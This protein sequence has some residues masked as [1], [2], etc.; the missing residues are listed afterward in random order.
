MNNT[1][2]SLYGICKIIIAFAVVIST[3]GLMLNFTSRCLLLY[4]YQIC[5][6]L[7]NEVIIELNVF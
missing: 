7:M 3:G 2:K 1:V 6:V 4:T 5:L